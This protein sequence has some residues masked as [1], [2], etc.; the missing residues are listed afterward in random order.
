MWVYVCVLVHQS[1]RMLSWATEHGRL[2]CAIVLKNSLLLCSEISLERAENR[3]TPRNGV[4]WLGSGA[5]GHT[6]T[7]YGK[8]IVVDGRVGVVGSQKLSTRAI[9]RI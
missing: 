5:N 4:A 3:R 8:Q 9:W 1:S 6:H 2:V 7:A